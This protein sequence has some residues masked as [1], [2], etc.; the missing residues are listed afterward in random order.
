MQRLV[1]ETEMI[2]DTRTFDGGTG[3]RRGLELDTRGIVRETEMIGD[4]QTFDVGR[5]VM[6][7]VVDDGSLDR[8]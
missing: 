1:R 6:V 2:G 8:R 5:T 3:N 7:V 4:A